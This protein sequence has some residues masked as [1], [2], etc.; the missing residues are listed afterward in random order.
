MRLRC[1]LALFVFLGC[2]GAGTSAL[3]RRGHH[4]ACARSLKW[5]LSLSTTSWTTHHHHRRYLARVHASL[6]LA[7]PGSDGSRGGMSAFDDATSGA[8]RSE[9]ER[10]HA[11]VSAVH[12][13]VGALKPVLELH[14]APLAAAEGGSSG[15]LSPSMSSSS[16]NAAVDPRG[17]FEAIA[18]AYRAATDQ[19]SSLSSTTLPLGP[20]GRALR[21][22]V[23]R[24]C[25]S[26]HASSAHHHGNGFGGGGSGG[27]VFG[28]GSALGPAAAADAALAQ[29]VLAAKLAAFFLA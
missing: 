10:F 1:M 12:T 7:A 18:S 9:V 17:L 24:L 14:A 19:P 25:D 2:F 29:D 21:R 27:G 15:A 20:R 28:P 3:R 26:L 23:G 11:A 4:P 22:L 16:L 5:K 6:F 13:A 8:A